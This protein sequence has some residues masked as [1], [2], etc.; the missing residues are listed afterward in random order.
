MKKQEIARRL[1][2]QAGVSRAEAADQLDRM[3]H[4][5]LSNLRKGKETP[6]PGLGKFVHAAD[7]SLAFEPEGN[8]PRE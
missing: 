5:I 3:V 2:R 8:K 1:A 7:G 6:L 4:Q